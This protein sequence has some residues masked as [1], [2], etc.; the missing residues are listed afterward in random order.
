MLNFLKLPRP[1]IS[2]DLKRLALRSKHQRGF[3]ISPALGG[4]AILILSISGFAF[5]LHYI[6]VTIRVNSTASQLK[7]YSAAAS[8][9]VMNNGGT[10]TTTLPLNGAA[11]T[12]TTAMLQNDG[13]LDSGVATTNAYGQS[14]TLQMRYVTQGSG[15]NIRNVIE[16]MLCTIGGTRISDQDLLRIASKV[17]AGG[18]ILSSDPTVA[19]GTNGQWAQPLSNFGIAPG[20]GHLCVGLFYSQAGAVADYLYRNAVTGHPEVNRMNTAIDMNNNAINNASTITALGK[21]TAGGNVEVGNYLQVDGVAALNQSC[22]PNG[23]QAR[24]ASGNS[25]VCT[26]GAWTRYV[27]VSGD[28]MSG[29]LQVNQNSWSLIAMNG[30]GGANAAA[31]SPTG[32]LYINDAY[33]R[34]MGK[35]LSQV[36]SGFGPHGPVSYVYPTGN[37]YTGGC[38]NEVFTDGSQ[39]STGYCWSPSPNGN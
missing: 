1:G 23:L 10:Y 26:N 30:S 33:V 4:L 7:A 19:L 25:L 5:A 34:S 28:T 35:W 20:P 36:L 29:T 3:F 37:A 24:D 15:A 22:S 32:S 31:Q 39:A 6:S 38:L 16:P 12:I 17:D 27:S 2:Q 14:Y 18:A 21:I 13:D 11:A 9:F 8:Q